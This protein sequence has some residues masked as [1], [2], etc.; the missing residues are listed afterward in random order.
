ME[1]KVMPNGYVVSE[2]DRPYAEL[3]ESGA[4]LMAVKAYKEAKGCGL[5][6]AKD[7]IDELAVKMG[8]RSGYD[9]GEG[10]CLSVVMVLIVGLALLA[11]FIAMIF[12]R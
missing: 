2:E 7:Y 9:K 6:E 8:I 12:W 5:K 11:G 3:I 1:P 4:T 10:S